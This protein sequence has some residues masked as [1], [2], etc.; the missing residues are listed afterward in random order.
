MSVNTGVGFRSRF[1]KTL[2]MLNLNSGVFRE[3]KRDN[4]TPSKLPWWIVV[5]EIHRWRLCIITVTQSWL[6]QLQT[7]NLKPETQFLFS[8]FVD[9]EEVQ[10]QSLL[11]LLSESSLAWCHWRKIAAPNACDKINFHMIPKCSHLQA[12]TC[13][14]ACVETWGLFILSPVRGDWYHHKTKACVNNPGLKIK[15]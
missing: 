13:N 12:V 6:N 1:V 9:P 14:L 8:G 7:P 10:I 3:R 11:I 4:L 15:P 5:S 2:S